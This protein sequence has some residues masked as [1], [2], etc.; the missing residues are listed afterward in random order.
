MTNPCN[1]SDTKVIF[2][3]GEADV[4]AFI[5]K[6]LAEKIDLFYC[7]TFNRIWAY[8]VAGLF[9]KL[10]RRLLGKFYIADEYCT[11]CQI[12]SRFCP[13]GTISMH[14]NKPYWNTTCEDCNRRINICP[15]KAIQVSL[16]LF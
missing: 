7:S 4:Q 12:C 3:T 5:E 13:A 14:Q 6:F 9:G 15:E 2:R 8:L 1:E 10:G 16:P 11:G